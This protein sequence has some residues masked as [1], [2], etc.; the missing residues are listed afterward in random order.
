MSL[1]RLIV[2]AVYLFVFACG[3]PGGSERAARGQDRKEPSLKQPE[4]S[5]VPP[6]MLRK[7]YDRA[8]N[9]T[10]VNVDIPLTNPARKNGAGNG[11]TARDVTL[12]FQ[13][14][15]KG[16]ATSDLSMV[17]L[18]VQ[19]LAGRAAEDVLSSVQQIEFNAEG[20]QYSYARVNYQ[21][22]LVEATGGTQ[23]TLPLKREIAVFKL[24]PDDLPQ[25]TNANSLKLKLGAEQFIVKSTQLTELRRTLVVGAK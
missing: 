17:Y 10:Y 22:E 21:T 25:M 3:A 12:I 4:K 16:A 13:L 15:Y 14:V 11:A 8:L 7:R 9:V 19:S 6:I 18:F 24:S 23:G 5:V 20:Y 2:S 1:V